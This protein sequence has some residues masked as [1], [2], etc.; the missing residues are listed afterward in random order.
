LTPLDSSRDEKKEVAKALG[1]VIGW[2][3]QGLDIPDLREARDVLHG[4][5]QF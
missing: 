4:L 2:F 3:P 1:D 5:S